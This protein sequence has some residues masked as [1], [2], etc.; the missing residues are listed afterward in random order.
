[1]PRSILCE[2][3]AT[4]IT[5]AVTAFAEEQ[6]KYLEKHGFSPAGPTDPGA[7]LSTQAVIEF[8]SG[9][10]TAQ[11]IVSICV[12]REFTEAELKRTEEAQKYLAAMYPF[13]Y[14]NL[15]S[16]PQEMDDEQD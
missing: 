15:G 1:M 16:E 11:T 4:G 12:S 9:A 7:P 6:A 8:L 10:A 3:T 5:D 14:K 13:I 2:S